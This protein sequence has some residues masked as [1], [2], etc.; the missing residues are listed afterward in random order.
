MTTRPTPHIHVSWYRLEVVVHAHKLLPAVQIIKIYSLNLAYVPLEMMAVR[1]LRCRTSKSPKTN[2]ASEGGLF[3]LVVWRTSRTAC[4][5]LHSVFFIVSC[6]RSVCV[7]HIKTD[8]ST[9]L[10]PALSGV[11]AVAVVNCSTA[12]SGVF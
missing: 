3:S 6:A 4:L 10:H 2:G 11:Y 5:W 1:V 12:G 9:H 7:L 8:I